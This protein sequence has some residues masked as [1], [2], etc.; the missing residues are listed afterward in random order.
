MRSRQRSDDSARSSNKGASGTSTRDA[1]RSKSTPLAPSVAHPDDAVKLQQSIGNAAL[2]YL[3]RSREPVQ[4]KLEVGRADDPQEREADRVADAIAAD[5]PA[6]ERPVRPKAEGHRGG[7]ITAPPSVERA[8]ASPGASLPGRVRSE[9][10]GAFDRDFS[11]V[12]LHVG[13]EAATATTE[14]AANAFTVGRDI[15]FAPGRFAPATREGRHLLAHELTHVAQQTSGRA[16][17]MARRQPEYPWRTKEVSTLP[18]TDEKTVPL[19]REA[20]PRV[21][22]DLQLLADEALALSTLANPVLIQFEQDYL[23]AYGSLKEILAAFIPD[24]G[25]PPE[26]LSFVVDLSTLAIPGGAIFKLSV[27]LANLGLDVAYGQAHDEGQAA[28]K[29]NTMRGWLQGTMDPMEATTV[30]LK[31]IPQI[32]EAA[33]H[34]MSEALRPYNRM[35]DAV[36]RASE[37]IPGAMEAATFLKVVPIVR[38]DID[39]AVAAINRL[40]DSYRVLIARL[41]G[42]R[43]EVRRLLAVVGPEVLSTPRLGLPDEFMRRV[44]IPVFPELGQAG[45]AR[46]FGQRVSLA[47]VHDDFLHG[48]GVAQSVSDANLARDAQTKGRLESRFVVPRGG[49]FPAD[50]HY[51]EKNVEQLHRLLET[52]AAMS[53]PSVQEAIARGDAYVHEKVIEFYSWQIPSHKEALEN[54]RTVILP[55]KADDARKLWGRLAGVLP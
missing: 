12:H 29:A 33:L 11:S 27:A 47:E 25:P 10:E 45:Q 40:E 43:E 18:R 41:G 35:E 34:L 17:K 16:N 31:V 46:P 28:L 26:I 53:L 55:S 20:L 50:P 14:I 22:R 48:T 6:I 52:R 38:T 54:A 15:V 8:V 51:R 2:T 32:H 7:G 37:P 36:L 21:T 23:A 24:W 44:L 3:I 30:A 5:G 49:E 1:V 4:A 9:M 39:I 42:Y 19:A 13:P